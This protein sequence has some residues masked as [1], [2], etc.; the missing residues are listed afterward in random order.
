MTTVV[1]PYHVVF[2]QD[3]SGK[4][5][6]QLVADNGNIMAQSA[7][8]YAERADMIHCLEVTLGGGY[9]SA[10]RPHLR[11]ISST[12][13]LAVGNVPVEVFPIKDAS[14]DL[15]RDPSLFEVLAPED[16]LASDVTVANHEDQG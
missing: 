9:L 1:P 12:K 11:R 2:K 8:G 16:T 5:R 15:E 4:H 6:W 14:E 10:P 13:G 3:R 7:Q